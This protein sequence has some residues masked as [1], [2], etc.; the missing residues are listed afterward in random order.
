MKRV[1]ISFVLVAA[2]VTG[3][4]VAE[5]HLATGKYK[6]RISNK[7]NCGSPTFN[8]P[9]AKGKISIRVKNSSSGKH[10]TSIGWKGLH[11]LCDDD[12]D[13]DPSD[14]QVTTLSRTATGSV[15]PNSSGSFSVS[16]SN[17]DGSVQF[18]VKGKFGHTSSGKHKVSGSIRETRTY[19]NNDQL[20]PSGS[21]NC[22]SGSRKYSAK[23]S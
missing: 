5:G 7:A 8:S 16:G 20:D 12:G 2:F 10:I 14:D 15:A 13:G 4:T 6:G 3:A 18:T 22:D 19:D 23:L 17:A 1:I 21:V 11:M 9:C